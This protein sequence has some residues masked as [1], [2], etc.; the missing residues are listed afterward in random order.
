MSEQ[1]G[2]ILLIRAVSPETPDQAAKLAGRAAKVSHDGEAVWGG[3]LGGNGHG[4][5]ESDTNRLRTVLSTFPLIRLAGMI[6]D[7]RDGTGKNLTGE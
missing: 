2:Q 1:I 3:S 6:G 5:R 4:I 7:I